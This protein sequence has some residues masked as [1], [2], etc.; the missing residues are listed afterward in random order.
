MTGSG[1]G[2]IASGAASGVQTAAVG[3][4]EAPVAHRH[5]V[6]ESETRPKC[7][8]SGGADPWHCFR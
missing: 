4:A 7:A 2:G 3:T 1:P 5:I 8:T 6:H